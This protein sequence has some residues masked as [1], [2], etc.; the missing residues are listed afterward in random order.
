MQ[1]TS[2]QSRIAVCIAGGAKL[3]PLAERVLGRAALRDSPGAYAACSSGGNASLAIGR[4]GLTSN[5]LAVCAA[6]GINPEDFKATKAGMNTTEEPASLVSEHE[7]C[8]RLGITPEEY[9]QA[10]AGAA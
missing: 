5:E 4:S 7:I 2:I 1:T 6:T 9:S 8:E 3:E 10:K